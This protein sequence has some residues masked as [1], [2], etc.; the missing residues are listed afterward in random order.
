MI[1]KKE[2]EHHFQT[3]DL[4]LCAALCCLG[5]QIENIEW[6]S[7]SR[8]MFVIRKDKKLEGLIEKY[9]AHQLKVEPV[10]F[11]NFLKEIKTR[12]YNT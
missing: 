10:N 4:A 11:F 6:R 8:A 9:F 2:N 1:Y 5:Y 12:I 7:A 3:S